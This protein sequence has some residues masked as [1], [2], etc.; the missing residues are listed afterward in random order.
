MNLYAPVAMHHRVTVVR[1]LMHAAL[2]LLLVTAACRGVPGTSP[3]QQGA[4]DQRRQEIDALIERLA[5]SDQPAG[6]EPIYTP[7]RD[8]PGTD[9][10]VIAIEAVGKLKTY[11]REAFPQLLARR[12]DRRQS[13]PLRRIVPHDVGLACYCI[14]EDQIYNLPRG[15]R[16]S[17]YRRGADGEL[18]QR[19]HFMAPGPFDETTI[20]AWLDA[21]RDRSLTEMQIEVLEWLIE[22]E[23][24]IGF[25][26]EAGREDYLV[27]LERQ[28]ERL[29]SSEGVVPRGR[30]A[31]R[32][33]WMAAPTAAR[34]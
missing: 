26:G 25:S 9:K 12:G 23:K 30:C 7:H 11:G 28:V 20:D 29:R 15:Y 31:K 5:L 1:A 2:G 18:H 34:S 19:P 24:A 17:F 3:A 14:V 8:T 32:S 21:R 16:G 22:Q 27:P 10:R 33:H 4:T 13:I 6:D